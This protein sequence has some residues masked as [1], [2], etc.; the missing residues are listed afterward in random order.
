MLHPNNF[1]K[2]PHSS[3]SVQASASQMDIHDVD[4]TCAPMHI[5]YSTHVI[6]LARNENKQAKIRNKH[7]KKTNFITIGIKLAQ[8]FN[9]GR[10]QLLAVEV[11]KLMYT[12]FKQV[13]VNLFWS[14]RTPNYNDKASKNFKERIGL[15]NSVSKSCINSKSSGSSSF[16]TPPRRMEQGRTPLQLTCSIC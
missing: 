3:Y 14:K 1:Q 4:Y 12:K 2:I 13:R 5:Q 9:Q 8:F 6:K 10:A 16:F 11:S 7:K 15:P